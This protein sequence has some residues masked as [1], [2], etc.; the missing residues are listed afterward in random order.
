MV[1]AEFNT[2]RFGMTTM[3]MVCGTPGLSLGALLV[4]FSVVAAAR[5][6]DST[7]AKV[8]IEIQVIEVATDKLRAIGFDWSHFTTQGIK[9][10]TVDQVLGEAQNDNQ[11]IADQLPGF[12]KA[13][14]Q[15][16]L[17]RT[18][19][20]PTLMTL[21]GRPASFALRGKKC[22]QLRASP[23]VVDDKHVRLDVQ[24]EIS[25]AENEQGEV[26]SDREADPASRLRVNSSVQVETG[27]TCII[28]RARSEGPANADGKPR[29]I[30]TLVLVR[31]DV[32][33]PE[34]QRE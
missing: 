3:R 22:I 7:A 4:A 14:E 6:E 19:S 26:A 24:L 17:A 29:Q 18:V 34:K 9:N 23:V 1:A 21:S 32:A 27:K 8:T 20:S 12:L 16:G 28:G 13:L 31:A 33:R 11:A 2:A 5:C 30:E 25:S 15:N 10:L